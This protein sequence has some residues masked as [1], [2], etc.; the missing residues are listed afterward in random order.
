MEEIL[1]MI[2]REKYFIFHAPRQTGKTSCLLAL[3]D[4]LNAEGK[5]FAM[6]VNVEPAQV[7]QPDVDRS[8]KAIV[9]EIEES[10]FR[11]TKDE[12]LRSRIVEINNGKEAGNVLSTAFTYICKNVD[13]PLV[14]IFDNMDAITGDTLFYVL[15]QIRSNFHTRPDTFPSSMIFSGIHGKSDYHSVKN[16]SVQITNAVPFNV[17]SATL[18]LGN[19]SKEEVIRLYAQHTTETGQIFEESIYDLVMEYTDGQPWLVNALAREVT[20]KMKENRDPA[21]I[22]TKDKLAE[23]KELLILERHTNLDLLLDKLKEDR[24]RRVIMPM[25]L[26]EEES[27]IEDGT[28]YCIDLGIVKRTRAGLQ[29]AN[30]IYK[31]VLSKV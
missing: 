28:Q 27:Y 2:Y 4:Y 9:G 13:K 11:L 22:I 14:F 12:K 31:E 26:G 5:Y 23:A 16:L 30:R 20:Y 29:I 19:F 24:V 18:T 3:E 17:I 6:Y 25:L 21:V 7:Y 10:L 15:R 1:E 8:V